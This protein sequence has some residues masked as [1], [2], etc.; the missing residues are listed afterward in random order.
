MSGQ[1]ATP[2]PP[3]WSAAWLESGVRTRTAELWRGVEAQHVVA[4][5]R[6]ADNAAEQRV[7]EE[8]LD[9]SK[10][11]PPPEAAGRH[12]LLFT[13]FRYRSP[14][15][16][17]F[18]R[19]HDPGV[20]YG[21]EELGTACGEVAYWKWRFLMDSEALR[22]SAL[23]TEHTFFKARVRGRCAD[24]TAAPWKKAARTWT[25]ASDFAQ[26]Q[27]LAA[28]ARERDLAWIRYAAVRVPGGTC[29]AVLSAKALSLAQP[30]EQQTWACKTAAAGAWLERAGGE[31]LEFSAADWR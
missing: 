27:A 3:G 28:L 7:L 10:P 1:A 5:M 6:L 8:L 21:A 11:A 9:A 17:R 14:F 20:W 23:H 13:P 30:F 22:D 24:L 31:R 29:G 15:P 4:T 16:S 18:R 25:H 26:C 12:Y 19:P 2:P